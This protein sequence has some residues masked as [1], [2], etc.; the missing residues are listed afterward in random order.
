MCMFKGYQAHRWARY[1][2]MLRFRVGKHIQCPGITNTCTYPFTYPCAG[3]IHV[4]HWFTW[5]LL[6]PYLLRI[7]EFSFV[8][9]VTTPGLGLHEGIIWLW[10]ITFLVDGNTTRNP[11][12]QYIWI[13]WV[14]IVGGISQDN[15]WRYT[16]QNVWQDLD[17]H[18]KGW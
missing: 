14:G 12:W 1:G 4:Q 11:I 16:W 8:G 17:L 5:E 2:L 18:T 9:S 13:L 7:L 6:V 3:Q 15:S 10:F